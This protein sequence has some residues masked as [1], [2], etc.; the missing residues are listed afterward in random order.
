MQEKPIL[1]DF[2]QYEFRASTTGNLM[3][4]PQGGTPF[5]KY[6]KKKSEIDGAFTKTT[7]KLDAAKEKRDAIENKESKGW[8]T[9]NERVQKLEG[10][11]TEINLKYKT[12]LEPLETD[13]DRI[14]LSATT[15]ACLL[16]IYVEEKTGRRRELTSRYVKKGNEA[17]DGSIS[18][19]SDVEDK[20]FTKNTERKRNGWIQGECDVPNIEEDEII[21]I[22]SSWDI[23]TFQSKTIEEI[24]KKY[25]WQG[26]CY[27]RL[28]DTQKYRIAYVLSNTPAGIIEDEKKRLL[29]AMGS[30]KVED[31]SYEQGCEEIELNNV[32][33]DIP[34]AERVIFKPFEYD[35]NAIHRLYARI[36][37][38]RKWLNDYAKA[39]YERVYGK[40]VESVDIQSGEVVEAEFEVIDTEFEEDEVAVID[41]AGVESIEVTMGFGVPTE[42]PTITKIK[43]CKTKDELIVLY[44]EVKDEFTA[45]ADVQEAFKARRAELEAPVV[46]VIPESKPAHA[47]APKAATAPPPVQDDDDDE[48]STPM[49]NSGSETE[50][51]KKI[52]LMF[53]ETDKC[54]T[55]VDVRALYKL[56][57]DFINATPILKAH[58][59][60]VG[61]EREA[62][63][64]A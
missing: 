47:P 33:D 30:N 32:F 9:A 34:N 48:V 20:M 56:H 25:W 7:E 63:P 44:K 1:L 55:A 57:K 11:L 40:A 6:I 27:M 41:I 26:Q 53:V 49:V 59:Q 38:C 31:K 36:T 62:N 46:T 15:I 42:K 22:K 4:D 37:E 19:L 60:K 3:V 61:K 24:D 64:L 51:S 16:Q 18:I 43:A 12:D 29:F 28:W 17:E 58:M 52:A 50:E 8:A 21:D 23:Y 35:E 45:N 14:V 5:D 39:E 13:K 10:E 2:S 54:K